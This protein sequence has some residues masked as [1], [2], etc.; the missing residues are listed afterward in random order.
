[1]KK[2]LVGVC[3]AISAYVV[4]AECYSVPTENYGAWGE[5]QVV[6]EEACNPYFTYSSACW[7]CWSSLNPTDGC[8][9]GEEYTVIATTY[10]NGY[11]ENG[12]CTGGIPG[13][14]GEFEESFTA[15]CNWVQSDAN[16]HGG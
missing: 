1:M 10:V 3:V 4:F 12:Y 16:C 11:C 5:C 13:P 8:I 7:A 14:Y 2:L 9:P 15:T 6:I